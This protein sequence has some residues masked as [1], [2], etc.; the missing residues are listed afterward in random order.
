MRDSRAM[1]AYQL[2]CVLPLL[3]GCVAV[4]DG[5]AETLIRSSTGTYL[6]RAQVETYGTTP[7][8]VVAAVGA[9]EFPMV[10][11]GGGRWEV[12]AP[13]PR[14]T[15][16][17][18]LRYLVRHPAAVGSGT[19]TDMEPPGATAVL[20]GFL[21]RVAPTAALPDCSA[22]P[23]FRV[24][25][26]AF[27]NDRD[28]M[29]GACNASPPGSAAVCTLQAAIEQANAIPGPA[30][31]ELPAGTYVGGDY[32]TPRD[33]LTIVGIAPGVIIPTHIS[34]FNSAGGQP[35]V[36][37]RNLT[38]RGGVRSDRGSLRLVAVR[39]ENSRPFLV[40]A[41]VMA[42]G[43]L[44]IED[45]TITGSGVVGVR[46]TGAH[47]RIVGSLIAD[48][49]LGG[50]IECAPQSGIATELTLDNTTVTGNF[51][52]FGGI[53]LNDRCRATLRNTTVAFNQNTRSSPFFG[54][55]VSA[56]V[57]L[58][59][60]AEL[61]L[62]NSILTDNTSTIDATNVDCGASQPTGTITVQSLGQNLI[63][64]SSSC[65][66]EDA[67]SRP[68]IRGV[69]AQLL[70]LANNGGATLTL[71]PRSTSP[72][73]GVGSTD[74]VSQANI[75]ACLPFDQRGVARAVRCDAGAA[76]VP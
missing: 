21:K 34:I 2:A 62:A 39:V 7:T 35:T 60:G 66:F 65:A 56:G 69:S 44:D 11:R 43:L 22:T 54:R 32:F 50:G 1:S 29:D 53:Q 28:L 16:G 9:T 24:N 8:E 58:D 6:L 17:F 37:L 27:L 63:Q 49:S 15:Q 19:V 70:P 5:V 73:R 31:I 59:E 20:G 76:E 67:L 72:A 25:S 36:E 41:G 74:A 42:L 40:D 33:D 10:D 38:L 45:S 61:V 13:L 30:K 64:T 14:C 51:G 47:G 12:T 23:V 68:D 18:Q 26:S 57:T 75:A 48:N 3:V 52:Q 4:D 46:L 55:R 71:L